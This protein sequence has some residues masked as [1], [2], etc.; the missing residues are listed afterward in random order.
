M[1]TYLALLQRPEAGWDVVWDVAG[2]GRD[3]PA[4][5]PKNIRDIEEITSAKKILS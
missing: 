4:S 5:S 2:S 1:M 3:I